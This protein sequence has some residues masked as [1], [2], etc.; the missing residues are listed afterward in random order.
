MISAE[1]IDVE[2]QVRCGLC[3]ILSNVFEIPTGGSLALVYQDTVVVEGLQCLRSS[4]QML[5]VSSC[6]SLASSR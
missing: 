5:F 2:L 4:R 3:D 1:V 6:D